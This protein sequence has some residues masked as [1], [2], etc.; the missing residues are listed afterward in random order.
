MPTEPKRILVIDDEPGITMMMK[1]N[2]EK[3]GRYTVQT[4]NDALTALAAARAFQPDLI[5]LDIVM[6]GKDGG[7]LLSELQADEELKSIP[8][9]FLTATMTAHAVEVRKGNIRGIPV[10]AKPVEPKKLIQRL[11]EVLK[12]KR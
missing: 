4:Q 9:V 7:E 5:L 8:V 2:L 3:S 6:P 10:I 11:E 1:L 12:Q